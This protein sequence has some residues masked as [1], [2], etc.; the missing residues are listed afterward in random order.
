MKTYK[1]LLFKPHPNFDSTFR[2]VYYFNNGFGISVIKGKCS[3]GL[4]E[5]CALIGNKS[6]S[7]RI[8]L[9]LIMDETVGNLTENEVTQYMIKLQ[10]FLNLN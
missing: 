1:N 9:P 10:T 3:I 5:I 7:D 8:S 2:A 6:K 4:H